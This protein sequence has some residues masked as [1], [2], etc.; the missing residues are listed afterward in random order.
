MQFITLLVYGY[1]KDNIKTI[2]FMTPNYLY[3]IQHQI[4]KTFY[5]TGIMSF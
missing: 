4:N 5:V 3:N 1:A 2:L